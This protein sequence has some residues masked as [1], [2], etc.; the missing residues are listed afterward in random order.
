MNSIQDYA[1]LPKIVYLARRSRELGK[2]A[3]A[4]K[5]SLSTNALREKVSADTTLAIELEKLGSRLIDGLMSGEKWM[6]RVE[7]ESPQTSEE[8][9][10]SLG[11]IGKGL[12][13]AGGAAIPTALA[14]TYL[15]NRA[16][17]EKEKRIRNLLLPMAGTVLGTTAGLMGLS[18]LGG[19]P[20]IVGQQQVRTASAKYG[21][22]DG[23]IFEKFAAAVESRTHLKEVLTGSEDDEVKKLAAETLII[24]NAHIADITGDVLLDKSAASLE[25]AKTSAFEKTAQ[26]E[27]WPDAP[28]APPANQFTAG[29]GLEGWSPRNYR[30]SANPLHAQLGNMGDRRF[31][32]NYGYDP[33]RAGGTYANALE[34]TQVPD[35]D[36]TGGAGQV[37]DYAGVSGTTPVQSYEGTAPQQGGGLIHGYEAQAPQTFGSQWE[38]KD[39]VLPGEARRHMHTPGMRAGA[40]R[41]VKAP[42]EHITMPGMEFDYSGGP[43]AQMLAGGG[44]VRQTTTSPV[45]SAL[46]NTQ[47]QLAQIASGDL[48]AQQLASAQGMD[49]SELARLQMQG[50]GL[51]LPFEESVART[52]VSPVGSPFQMED[53]FREEIPGIAELGGPRDAT[54]GEIMDAPAPTDTRTVEDVLQDFNAGDYPDTLTSSAAPLPPALD[55]E[56]LPVGWEGAAS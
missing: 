48:S 30:T 20:L 25:R 13:Y 23:S 2:L 56:D 47:D 22:I 51:D 12:A 14:G 29:T 49:P 38:S 9:L 6:E 46:V 50:A 37:Q 43:K 17:A 33:F 54:P 52:K 15:I 3:S 31:W 21:S 4:D 27:A 32:S 28:Q 41:V 16:G 8:K 40:G 18:R 42:E 53:D 7:A 45:P 10:G 24:A 55:E 35:Y 39:R 5:G 1:V 26:G 44:D 34:G 19:G 11:A 36:P